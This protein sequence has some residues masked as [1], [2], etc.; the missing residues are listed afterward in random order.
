MRAGRVLLIASRDSLP[1]WE[2][3]LGTIPYTVAREDSGA[4]PLQELA[5]AS[6]CAMIDCNA[7]EPIV[8]AQT[9]F[10]VDSGIQVILV[11]DQAARPA[12]E[13]SI[14][15]TPGL[16]EIWIH[17][18]DQ[19]DAALISRAAKVTRQRRRFRNTREQ[20]ASAS[21][22][23]AG[24]AERAV[25]S[26]GFLASLLQLLPTAVFTVNME[27]LVVGAN[28]A[29]EALLG[30]EEKDMVSRPFGEVL[31]VH[32]THA[33]ARLLRDADSEK[34]RTEVRFRRADG[35]T[36]F[37]D[38]M[39]VHAEAGR[40][41]VRAVVVHDLTE[42]HR[43]QDQLEQQAV[44]LEAMN[45]ELQ[46]Q[47]E[48]LERALGAR[49]R[50]YASMS[51]ELRTPI[52]AILGYS[53][54]ILD[55][56]Y[57][58]LAPEQRTGFE[59]AQRA[60]RH[61]LELVNDVLDLAKIEA[62]RIEI[63]LEPVDPVQVASE[64]MDTVR[65]LAEKHGTPMSFKHRSC[66][67]P[68]VTDPRRM[69]Q[70]MLNLLSNAIKFGEGKP[71]DIRCS[72]GKNGGFVFRVIDQGPGI[73]AEHQDRIFEEFVQLDPEKGTASSLG[74]GLGLSISRRLAMLL[75]GTLDVT[76]TPGKGSTFRL[77]LPAHAPEAAFGDSGKEDANS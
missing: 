72:P 9:L 48:E 25:I 51:H 56:V 61:L 35:E 22:H 33:L 55:G 19:I 4:A 63:Q 77:T 44:E 13:R 1:G 28:S 2:Q 18:P 65:P 67:D 69:R 23:A 38:V 36:G 6:D 12:L 76:S 62:G 75:G 15:F 49:A 64:L 32:D 41:S 52:N 3:Q 74:T 39:A 54:L 45:I 14:L 37:G 43:T 16:G 47:T 70:I 50:F 71:V 57:G 58:P 30:H 73:S 20:I 40:V 60:A 68:I 8:V 53:S 42:H 46:R 31:G 34:A 66:D 24:R 26:D 59:R 29:A 10:T 5:V 17:G 11:C 21:L 27:G 7:S